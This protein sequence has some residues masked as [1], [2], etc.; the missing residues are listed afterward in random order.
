MWTI[1]REEYFMDRI[2]EKIDKESQGGLEDY[3]DS[4]KYHVTKEKH[5]LKNGTEYEAY[6]WETDHGAF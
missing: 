2:C 3:L 4:M 5:M 1:N 6:T